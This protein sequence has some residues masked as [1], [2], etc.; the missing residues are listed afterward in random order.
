MR[1]G[2]PTRH[3]ALLDKADR[4]QHMAVV[5]QGRLKRSNGTLCD[6]GTWDEPYA[7][8]LYGNLFIGVAAAIVTPTARLNHSSLLAGK[9][10]MCAGTL[11]VQGGILKKFNNNSGHYR[12]SGVNVYQRLLALR[13][14][15]VDLS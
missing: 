10:V 5:D 8:G 11:R 13:D 14:E 9:G 15:H 4:L 3:V 2:A 7:M 6:T 12:P 1:A